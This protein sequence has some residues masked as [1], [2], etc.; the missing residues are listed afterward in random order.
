MAGNILTPNAIW[1]GFKAERPF[2]VESVN[3]YSRG[4]IK[5][6]ELIIEGRKIGEEVVEISALLAASDRTDGSSGVLILNDLQLGM[7]IKLVEDLAKKG[8]TVLAV[9]LAGKAESK[10]K[11]T[12]YPES[13]SYANYNEVKDSLFTVKG[14]V[15]GTCWY[16]WTCV[17]RYALAVMKDCFDIKKVGGIASRESA[18]VLWQVAGTD[19]KLDC[20]VFLLNAGWAGYRGVYKFGGKVEPQFDDDMYKFIAGVEPQA[21]AMHVNC[22]T[23]MLSAT[24]SNVYD[25]DRAYDTVSRISEKVYRAV[26]Y[27]V[28][29][30]NRVSSEAYKNSTLFFESFLKVDKTVYLPNEPEIKCEI[31]NGKIVFDVEVSE[32]ELKRV[33]VYVSEE[34]TDPSIRSWQRLSKR[35]RVRDGVYRFEYAPYP[36]SGIVTAF[37]KVTYNNEFS[38]C[39]NVIA[40]R[41]KEN[42]INPAYK[43]NVLYTSREEDLE[44]VF[45]VAAIEGMSGVASLSDKKIIK[46]KKGPMGIEGIYSEY[47]LVTFKVGAK[48]FLPMDGAMLMMDVYAKEKSVL[49]VKLISD[50]AGNKI[51]YIARANVL[52]GDVWHNVQLDMNKFKTEEG[53]SLKS[54]EKINAVEFN[55]E[56]TEYLINNVLW[57]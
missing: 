22:P 17:A 49:S 9:D 24:N 18:T 51:E 30:R 27:S 40:K 50:Y 4:G 2:G 28:S 42:E 11:F 16:E 35:V 26:H 29:Y 52:G 41:F 10:E 31:E 12:V 8:Y 46:L 36:Q 5:Y 44:S 20:A 38:L 37:A 32:T 56:G 14:D 54:Y 34:I 6:V 39:T 19:E 21:Y 55:V 3:S 7:D 47:G 53:M 25:F 45:G 33:H 57:V 23:L 48:R 43:I 1:K 13:V 15:S